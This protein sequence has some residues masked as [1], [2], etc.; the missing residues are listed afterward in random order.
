VGV[1]AHGLA[2][3]FSKAR[4]SGWRHTYQNPLGIAITGSLGVL[5]GLLVLAS[6]RNLWAVI[7]GHGLFDASRFVLFYFKGRRLADLVGRLLFS[8]RARRSRPTKYRGV[9]DFKRRE[10]NRNSTGWLILIFLKSG[11]LGF[12]KKFIS[13]VLNTLGTARATDFPA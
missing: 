2:L 11:C 9:S 8:R 7:I 3:V 13:L 4:S 10:S 12:N 6:G 1:A 5:M